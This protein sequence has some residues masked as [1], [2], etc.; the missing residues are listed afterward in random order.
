MPDR[1]HPCSRLWQLRCELAEI[2][3]EAAAA[4][5]A[6]RWQREELAMTKLESWRI[7]E[8]AQRLVQASRE[9]D[10]GRG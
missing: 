1:T 3:A 7:R 10:A 4:R 6:T 8:E 2:R 5:R 9:Q